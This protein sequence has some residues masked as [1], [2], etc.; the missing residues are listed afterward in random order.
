MA[1]VVGIDTGKVMLQVSRLGSGFGQQRMIA[2]ERK[3]VSEFTAEVP[4]ALV[5]PGMLT[6]RIILQKGNDYVVFPENVKTNPFA[7]DNYAVKTYLTFV[8]ANKAKLE[9][10]NP[11]TDRT[12]RIYPS[13]RRGFQSSYTT[14]SESL[15]LILR[16]SASELSGDHIMGMQWYLRDKLNGRMSEV[17]SMSKLV[18]RARTGEQQSVRAKITLTNKDAVS[19]S[20]FITLTNTFQE[21]EVP[22]TNMV[23]DSALL[24]PRPYPG[25]L[26]LKFKADAPAGKLKLS[27][28]EKIEII[29]GDDLQPADFNKPYSMEVGRVWLE[30]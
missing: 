15:Q 8:A 5:Q 21:I 12:A 20:T 29:V 30:R 10:F 13:F 1:I 28:I 7:W 2:M 23:V 25:F 4:A 9:I 6:Y 18:I 16:L 14:G 17:D 11:T 24:L 19:F 22:L 3:S 26:P 27:E